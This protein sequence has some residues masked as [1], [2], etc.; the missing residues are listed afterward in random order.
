MAQMKVFVSHSHQDN[1]FCMGLVRA[2]SRAGAD[3]WYD[4]KNLHTGQLGPIIEREL[5]EWPVFVVV[6]SPAALASRWVEDETRW[7]YNRLRRDPTRI[8]LPVLAEALPDEDDIWLFLRE[9][10]RI[11]ATGSKPFPPAQAVTQTLR[12]LALAAVGAAPV[13]TTPQPAE[14]VDDLIAHGKALYAQRKYLEALPFIER[15]TILDPDTSIALVA[16]GRTY[17]VLNRLEE[18]LAACECSLKLNAN[19]AGAWYAK[20][21]VLGKL[22]RWK[23]AQEAYD[24]ATTLDPQYATRWGNMGT[25]LVDAKRWE[26]ALAA[27]RRAIVLDEKDANAWARKGWALAE[28]GRWLEALDAFEQATTLDPDSA[29]AWTG[30]SAALIEMGRYKD[31]LDA[32]ERALAID[33]YEAVGWHNQAVALRGI[34][35]ARE[36][37]A[38]ERRAKKMGWQG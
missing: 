24:H 5:R 11:G 8:L 35:R 38:A 36:A 10:K 2:L 6:L 33:P 23:E 4:D 12:A 21:V 22:G 20:G 18:G 13:P 15:A 7:A 1:A 19:F 29:A 3:V 32:A 14:S 26:E 27:S 30:K 34:G 28:L 16:L 25:A 37:D 17:T 31:A 9:F